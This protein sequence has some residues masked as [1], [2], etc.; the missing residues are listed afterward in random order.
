MF[1]RSDLVCSVLPPAVLASASGGRCV[2]QLATS[3]RPGAIVHG[4]SVLTTYPGFRSL[5][6]FVRLVD[7]KQALW[8]ER[9]HDGG[10]PERFETWD[11][12]LRRSYVES[13]RRAHQVIAV[14]R[15]WVCS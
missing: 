2:A 13:L 3:L 6:A 12:S 7:R 15:S 10:L 8:L 1:T 9:I 5:E 14:A 4:H 11:K